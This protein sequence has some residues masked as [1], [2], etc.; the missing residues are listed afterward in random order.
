VRGS[1]QSQPEIGRYQ[2]FSDE[3]QAYLSACLTSSG[4]STV[5]GNEFVGKMNRQIL[6][7]NF[8]PGIVGQ[9]SL[10]ERRC[11]WVHLSTP[12]DQ[13]SPKEGYQVLES[14]FEE[15]YSRWQGVF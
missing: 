9:R 13:G 6:R 2:L 4:E 8:F 5:T 11:L 3:S 14:V 1:T 7:E 10:R 15:G 12:L